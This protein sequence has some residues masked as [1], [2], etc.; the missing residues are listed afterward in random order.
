VPEENLVGKAFFIWLSW[1]F[2]G[3]QFKAHRIGTSIR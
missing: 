1:D 2:S 3:G